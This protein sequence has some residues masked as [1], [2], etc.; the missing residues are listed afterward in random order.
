MI[1]VR[2]LWNFNDAIRSIGG[3]VIWPE[4]KNPERPGTIIH[5]ARRALPDFRTFARSLCRAL[6]FHLICGG[7]LPLVAALPVHIH[8]HPELGWAMAGRT[9][10][11]LLVVRKLERSKRNSERP[12]M[13]ML[14]TITKLGFFSIGIGGRGVAAPPKWFINEVK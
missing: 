10:F 5:A 8:F 7:L 9:H 4:W 12:E 2:K 6:S 14:M 11:A 3:P 13:S 1:L